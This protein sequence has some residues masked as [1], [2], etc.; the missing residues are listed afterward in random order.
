MTTAVLEQISTI[1]A[2]GQTTVPK[3]VRDALG[4]HNGDRI[5]FCVDQSG[6]RV[7]LHRA[8]EPHNDPVFDKFLTF[9]AKDLEQHPD[10]IQAVS[11]EL[12]ERIAELT[13]VV[14]VDLDEAIEGDVSM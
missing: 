3:A 5:A 13:A 9:L 7:T 10:H 2:K 14:E 8:D 6:Q 12:V 11:R 4:L 1:T